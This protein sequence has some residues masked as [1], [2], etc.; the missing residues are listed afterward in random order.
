MIKRYGLKVVIGAMQSRNIASVNTQGFLH[1]PL[2][3]RSTNG[4]DI[5]DNFVAMPSS[6]FL[7]MLA[8]QQ[9]VIIF[10]DSRFYRPFF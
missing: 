3:Q 9:S 4:Q 1:I 10:N 2:N 8:I 5:A 6:L 7:G